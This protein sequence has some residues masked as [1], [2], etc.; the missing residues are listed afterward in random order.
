MKT[1]N[2]TTAKNNFGDLM[3][4]SLVEPV[5]IEKNGKIFS[6]ASPFISKKLHLTIDALRQY[7]DMSIGW[8]KVTDITGKTLPEVISLMDML[9][10]PLPSVDK[11][12]IE[13]MSNDVVDFLAKEAALND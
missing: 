13:S 9:D 11:N 1:F 7:S 2:A 6:V 3:R 8:R 12:L 4:S 10:I 5:A